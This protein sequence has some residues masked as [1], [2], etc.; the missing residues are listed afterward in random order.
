MGS[1]WGQEAW[2]TF[3]GQVMRKWRERSWQELSGAEYLFWFSGRLMNTS[4]SEI[5]LMQQYALELTTGRAGFW[6]EHSF[7]WGCQEASDQAA[8]IACCRPFLQSGC[9]HAR[10]VLHGGSH[11]H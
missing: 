1:T 11:S 10:Q 9:D 6:G 5:R 8:S 3:P 7:K 2:D 4:K